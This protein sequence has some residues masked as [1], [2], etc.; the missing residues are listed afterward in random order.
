MSCENEIFVIQESKPL[1]PLDDTSRPLEN[2]NE[3]NVGIDFS[4]IGEANENESKK[5]AKFSSTKKLIE[6][7]VI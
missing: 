7:T 2:D 1:L 3:G 4:T 6:S 5:E